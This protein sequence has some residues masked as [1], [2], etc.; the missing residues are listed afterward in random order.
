MTGTSSGLLGA[1]VVTVESAAV[2]DADEYTRL[3]S[4][5]RGVAA[6]FLIPPGIF[7]HDADYQNPY[8]QVD[9]ERARA[10]AVKMKLSVIKMSLR[11][12]KGTS[13]L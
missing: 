4:N 6:Q 12:G 5:G 10:L 11:N 9:V 8:R 2:V 3:F 1:F 13:C 7:G